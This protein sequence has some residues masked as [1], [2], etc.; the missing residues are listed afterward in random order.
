MGHQV[1]AS[2]LEHAI[3]ELKARLGTRANDT[4]AVR[5]HHSHGESYHPPAPPDIVCF[6]RT[7]DEVA[8]IVRISARFQLPIVPFGAGTSL[9]GHVNAIQGG[10][11]STCAMN[12]SCAPAPRIRRDGRGRRHAAAVEQGAQQHRLTFGRPGADATIGG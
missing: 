9:E 2:S 10:I 6:P 7:T 11:T 4:P 12:R 8:E 3:L 5:E 1:T